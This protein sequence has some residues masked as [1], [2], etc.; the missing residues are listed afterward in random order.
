MDLLKII[1]QMKEAG[2][3]FSSG[4]TNDT[5]SKIEEIYEIRFPDSLKAFYS[6]ALP[7]SVGNTKFPEWNDFSPE[8]ILFIRQLIRAPYQWLK[9]DI[10]R[11]FWLSIWDGKTADELFL[12][13]PKLIPIYSHRYVPMLKH[14]DPP[15]I[16]TVG[17]DTVCYGASLEDYLLREFCNGGTSF[18]KTEVPYIP[19]WSDILECE[20]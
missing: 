11:G 12:N 3:C 2:V 14:S 10:E 6:T 15:V 8:N 1:K 7:I 19:L 18:E 5:I 9:Q 13:A 16:S 20:R 17:R 4:L